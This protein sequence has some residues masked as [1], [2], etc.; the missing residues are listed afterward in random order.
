M[1]KADILWKKF[2]QTGKVED[3][4]AF[5]QVKEEEREGDLRGQG[6]DNTGTVHG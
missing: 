1:D 6:T 5:K 4:L 3:Y 2:E